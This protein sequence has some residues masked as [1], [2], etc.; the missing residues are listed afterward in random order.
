M[1]YGILYDDI[2]SIEGFA[3]VISM[4]YGIGTQQYEM[5]LPGI[6][7]CSHAIGK[8]KNHVEGIL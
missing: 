2:N 4:A 5:I 3:G 1:S 7:L 6:I 8:Y